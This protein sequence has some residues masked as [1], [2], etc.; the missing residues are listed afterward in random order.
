MANLNL[1]AV[2]ATLLAI[3]AALFF[4]S[5]FFF[6]SC[7]S[8][9]NGANYGKTNPSDSVTIIKNAYVIE[10]W[11]LKSN[12]GTSFVY[13]I[14]FSAFCKETGLDARATDS[15]DFQ[16]S[17]SLVL[18]GND[19]VQLNDDELIFIKTEG[20][21]SEKPGQFVI[22][23]TTTDSFKNNN[24]NVDAP[25]N[26]EEHELL[27]CDTIMNMFAGIEKTIHTTRMTNETVGDSIIGNDKFEIKKGYLDVTFVSSYKREYDMT[28]SAPCRFMVPAGTIIITYD[29]GKTVSLLDNCNG[30]FNWTAKFWNSKDETQNITLNAHVNYVRKA[31]IENFPTS[32]E[33]ANGDNKITLTVKKDGEPQDSPS[34]ATENDSISTRA[35]RQYYTI[36]DGKGVTAKAYIDYTSW[37][38]WRKSNAVIEETTASP[39]GETALASLISSSEVSGYTNHKYEVD[40]FAAMGNCSVD[41]SVE[42]VMKEQNK[43]EDKIEYKVENNR[44]VSWN[45]AGG[46]YTSSFD[47]VKYVNGVKSETT[48]YTKTFNFKGEAP[49]DQRKLVKDFNVT[50]GTASWNG[51]TYTTKTNKANFA[52][53]F[54]IEEGS[55]NVENVG[56]V[57]YASIKDILSVSDQG[58]NLETISDLERGLRS[59]IKA[60]ALNKSITLSGYAVLY[61]E[62][63]ADPNDRFNN[64]MPCWDKN[65]GFH[66]CFIIVKD[67]V[68][69]GYLDPVGDN[70][71]PVVET[72]ISLLRD[73]TNVNEITMYQE[74]DGSWSLATISR[75]S[76][77]YRFSA[78]E[79]SKYV[80]GKANFGVHDQLAHN[81]WGGYTWENE[82]KVI[83][84]ANGTYTGSGVLR[85]LSVDN[86]VKQTITVESFTTVR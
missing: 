35:S 18:K 66:H 9:D 45:E 72:N 50:T 24:Y 69:A 8:V 74:A 53:R 19:I 83:E 47:V 2:H 61:M 65:F 57:K 70:V 63:A 21:T 86:N 71:K 67:D 12:D 17:G 75:S 44:V 38:Q 30:Y 64:V 60:S 20:K 46:T 36:S 32:F 84:N 3:C 34:L 43:E 40:F 79:T 15:R 22:K 16:V 85:L 6:T 5:S 4:M 68:I 59:T 80:A 77:Y 41:T 13:D 73:L 48:P 1:K 56:V 62:K 55:E 49:A 27:A 31:V 28:L 76:G 23:M 39:S 51:L 82:A 14:N 11:K 10:S 37:M 42:T 29:E 54:T 33:R 58:I 7:D 25:Y 78:L 26:G 52:F 81:M